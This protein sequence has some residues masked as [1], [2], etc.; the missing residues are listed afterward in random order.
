MESV[1]KGNTH[2]LTVLTIQQAIRKKHNEG[3]NFFIFGDPY[4]TLSEQAVV[5]FAIFLNAACINIYVFSSCSFLN[6]LCEGIIIWT[7]FS[8]PQSQ[9]NDMYPLVGSTLVLNKQ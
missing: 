4:K 8:W 3:S 9:G 7:I 2:V 6:H 1:K 5:L